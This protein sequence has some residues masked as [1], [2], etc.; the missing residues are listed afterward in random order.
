MGSSL[1]AAG[2]TTATSDVVPIAVSVVATLVLVALWRIARMSSRS[3]AVA[4]DPICGM[5]VDTSAPGAVRHL[6]HETYYFCSPRCAARFDERHATTT[7]PDPSG[8]AM[9]PA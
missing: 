3:A 2:G 9:D 4:T 8:G 7:L 1:L 5:T 6:H